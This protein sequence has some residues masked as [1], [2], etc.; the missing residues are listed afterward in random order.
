VNYTV[1]G[2]SRS[3]SITE[4]GRP[5]VRTVYLD[6]DPGYISDDIN[7]MD[8]GFEMLL[9]SNAED[10]H[11]YSFEF[12]KVELEWLKYDAYDNETPVGRKTIWE[13]SFTEGEGPVFFGPYG[14][15]P[16]SEDSALQYKAYSFWYE[17]LDAAPPD[18]DAV[19]FRLH[20]YGK[21]SGDDSCDTPSEVYMV[22]D[23]LELP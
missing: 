13:G 22:T 11:D 1:G 20:F 15:Y 5:T 7:D 17:G 4:S 12:S 23:Y 9:V 2:S 14:P 10:P 3:M 18:D 21:V 6:Y 19:L 16:S 8:I